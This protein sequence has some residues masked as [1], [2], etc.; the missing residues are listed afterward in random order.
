[1]VIPVKNREDS[2][3]YFDVTETNDDVNGVEAD[4]ILMAILENSSDEPEIENLHD[5][6]GHENF[7]ALTLSEEE[8]KDVIKAHRYFGHRSG[9]KIWEMFS[10]AGRLRKKKKE[11]LQL[12]EK[13]AV[14]NQMKKTPPRPKIAIPVAN[15]FNEIVGLDLKVLTGG[16]GYILWCVDM[17]SKLIKGTFI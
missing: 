12:L 11:V 14:C 2:E 3:K 17:F 5:L 1:M 6:I 7:V 13:C 4:V 9:R 15:D 16:Q 8:R 10:K